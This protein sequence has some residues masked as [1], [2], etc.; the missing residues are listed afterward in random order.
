M[1]KYP[2]EII[3]PEGAVVLRAPESCRYA[4][5]TELHLIEAGYTIRLHGRK[6]TK[7]EIKKGGH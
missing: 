1:M 7:T 3:N 5:N 4:K 2:Y 6:V